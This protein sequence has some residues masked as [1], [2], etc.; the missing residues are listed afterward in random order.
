MQ[1]WAVKLAMIQ[2]TLFT[3]QYLEIGLQVARLVSQEAKML[4]IQ[5]ACLQ[6]LQSFLSVKRIQKRI[7]LAF[8]LVSGSIIR[9]KIKR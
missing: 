3:F 5:L 1:F 9:Q 2:L 6:Y 4:I 8:H 7:F